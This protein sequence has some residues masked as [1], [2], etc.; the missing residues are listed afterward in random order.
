MKALVIFSIIVLVLAIGFG[1]IPFLLML[2]WN[3][4]APVFGGPII[5]FWHSL[6]I[7]VLLS[8]FSSFFKKS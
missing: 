4:L 7:V 2:C 6:A 5:S 3:F 8:I 1:L